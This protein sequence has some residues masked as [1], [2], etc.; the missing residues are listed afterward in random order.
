MVTAIKKLTIGGGGEGIT[1]WDMCVVGEEVGMTN[2]GY[3]R[4]GMK[5]I[6]DWAHC[7]NHEMN[8]GLLK[9]NNYDQ[10]K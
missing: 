4:Y 8:W 5:K 9:V 6:R 2:G 1:R 7:K 10:L 3:G